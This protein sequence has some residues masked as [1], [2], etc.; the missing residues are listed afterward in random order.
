MRTETTIVKLQA[1]MV[2]LGKEAAGSGR[3]YFT[4]GASALL[5]EWR[6]STI[7]IDIKA[8]PEPEGFFEAIALLKNE[9]DVNIE[10]AAPDQFIPALPSW[11]DRSVFVVRH[12]KLDFY[13]YDFFSQALAKIERGHARDITDVEA[14]I[15]LKLISTSRLFELYTEIEPR[16]IRYPAITP[17]VFRKSVETF[18]AQHLQP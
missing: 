8:D 10:L 16:L 1:F 18:C 17:T 5:Y 12:G 4:G 9:L 14:M 2:A 11:Q 6:S 13:H 7:D 3:I 15:R